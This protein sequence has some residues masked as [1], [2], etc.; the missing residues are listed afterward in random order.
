M[1]VN[2]SNAVA[3]NN[4][5][6]QA[7][8]ADIKGDFKGVSVTKADVP[9][10][11]PEAKGEGPGNKSI[12]DFEITALS[13]DQVSSLLIGNKIGIQ[14]I[15]D[16]LNKFELDP[17]A[18]K[19][20]ELIHSLNQSLD[21]L[22]TM[23]NERLT[24]RNNMIEEL[25][26]EAG[27]PINQEVMKYENLLDNLADELKNKSDKFGSGSLREKADKIF[28]HIDSK[29]APL[30][31]TISETSQQI[32]SENTKPQELKKV[33]QDAQNKIMEESRKIIDFVGDN[34]IKG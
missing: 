17:D 7:P 5:T 18:G 31:K 19:N 14:T 27:R 8:V 22:T 30:E 32:E 3:V 11:L 16:A 12:Q 20:Y 6:T 10:Q 23:L 24:E 26:A 15:Q 1:N 9:N 33:L 29:I 13:V 34:I 28:D 2:N 21:K 4:L 25:F